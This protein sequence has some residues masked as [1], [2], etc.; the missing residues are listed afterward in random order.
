MK[1]Y[2]NKLIYL[3]ICG[4]LFTN[5]DYEAVAQEPVTMDS[6]IKTYIYNP[7]EVFPVILHYGYHNHIDFPKNEFITNVIVGNRADWD[8]TNNGNRIFLQTY[9]RSA[10]TNMTVITNKRTYE[11]D[12]IAKGELQETD[13]DLAYAIRFYYPE[14][15]KVV[16]AK[17]DENESPVT[18]EISDL[19]KGK[20]NANYVYKGDP[21]LTPIV[22]FNDDRHTYLKFKNNITPKVETYSKNGAKKEVKVFSYNGYIIINNIFSKIRLSYNKKVVNLYNKGV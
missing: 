12:L 1:M 22:A 13:Y 9:S 15:A 21:D 20:I 10:H 7:N 8:I 2:N 18:M 11:F 19:V 3:L 4:F 5:F 17:Y 6:R 14:E 16:D